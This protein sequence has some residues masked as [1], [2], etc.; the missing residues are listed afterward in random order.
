MRG[1]P[2]MGAV[3]ATAMALLTIQ[4]SVVLLQV[5]AKEITWSNVVPRHNVTGDVM[6]AHDG[7]YNQWGG[8]C[9]GAFLVW[10]LK[11]HNRTM[12][13]FLT[14]YIMQAYIT[15]MYVGHSHTRVLKCHVLICA[16][17]VCVYVLF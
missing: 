1:Y 3:E 2:R 9:H 6:D 13:P 14:T 12:Y 11:C 15:C 16:T 4:T 5:N 8:R 17:L 10:R 7:T